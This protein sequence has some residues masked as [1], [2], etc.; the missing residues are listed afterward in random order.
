MYASD[1]ISTNPKF[2]LNNLIIPRSDL[3]DYLD[4]VSGTSNPLL[5]IDAKTV[6]DFSALISVL[7]SRWLAMNYS[8]VLNSETGKWYAAQFKH[9]EKEVLPKWIEEEQTI[10]YI[11]YL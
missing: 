5:E 6:R 3:Q 9:F 4:S 2:S 1:T 11:K 7:F 10:E 8:E